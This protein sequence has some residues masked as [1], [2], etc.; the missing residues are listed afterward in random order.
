MIY[1]ILFSDSSLFQRTLLRHILSV[2]GSH[3]F[4]ALPLITIDCVISFRS[5]WFYILFLP[6]HFLA[7]LLTLVDA[8]YNADEAHQNHDDW[9]PNGGATIIAFPLLICFIIIATPIVVVAAIV[10]T[11]TYNDVRAGITSTAATTA[12]S[13]T[14]FSQF[15]QTNIVVIIIIDIV[16]I[17]SLDNQ[18]A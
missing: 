6:F 14:T 9:N 11:A 2:P 17:V 7:L 10:I 1:D 16:L 4:I 12:P 5:P 15:S 3:I 18:K 13:L 8:I